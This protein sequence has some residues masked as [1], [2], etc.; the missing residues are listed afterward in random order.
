M[1]K[2]NTVSW[3]NVDERFKI[4]KHVYAKYNYLNCKSLLDGALFLLVPQLQVLATPK[5]HGQKYAYSM[6]VIIVNDN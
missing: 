4:S 2:E 1:P 5:H 3:P 6:T